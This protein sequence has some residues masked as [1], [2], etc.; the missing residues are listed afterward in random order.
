MMLDTFYKSEPYEI[1]DDGVYEIESCQ[2]ILLYG[3]QIS[4]VKLFLLMFA[5]LFSKK[6]N[7]NQK[8]GCYSVL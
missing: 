3:I 8:Y 1:D 6:K 2:Y 4:Q 5:N 7:L